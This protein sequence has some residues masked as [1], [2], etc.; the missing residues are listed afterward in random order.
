MLPAAGSIPSIPSTANSARV[1]RRRGIPNSATESWAGFFG[2]GQTVIRGGYSRIYGRLNGG[3]VVERADNFEFEGVAAGKAMSWRRGEY[4]FETCL[5]WLVGS[6]PGADLRDYWEELF[7]IPAL[8]LS[9]PR[10]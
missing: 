3:R 10:R 8:L 6:K 9:I 7:D 1:W 5:H 4:T 2:R